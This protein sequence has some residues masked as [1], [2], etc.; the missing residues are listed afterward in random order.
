[1]N[2]KQTIEYFTVPS[3]GQ[4]VRIRPLSA[5][6]K[7]QLDLLREGLPEAPTY[8]ITYPGGEEE[9]VPHDPTTLDT[10][11]ERES[12][13]RFV[14]KFQEASTE[15]TTRWVKAV[16]LLCI[17]D[18]EYPEG[19]K[20]DFEYLG[21][22]IP[23]DE[24]EQ[25]IFFINNILLPTEED[26]ELFAQTVVTISTVR[27]E[28]LALAKAEFRDILPRYSIEQVEL[29]S[30]RVD[31]LATLLGSKGDGTVEHHTEPVGQA[32]SV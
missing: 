17:L 28:D 13:L 11:E 23:E 31:D 3:T 1:V 5:D 32:E 21:I 24:R 4:K 9:K 19:W 29:P 18:L 10:P 2:M 27:R 6:V 30:V 16:V 25:R 12:W 22:E 8:T 26:K 20:D 7:R 15:M 14:E